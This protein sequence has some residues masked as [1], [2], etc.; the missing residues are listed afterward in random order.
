MLQVKKYSD[1]LRNSPDYYVKWSHPSPLSNQLLAT[2]F[3][4]ICVCRFQV[5]YWIMSFLTSLLPESMLS[6][7]TESVHSTIAVSNLPGP[8][9]ITYISGYRI[10]NMTFWLPHRGSTGIGISILSY[11]YKLQLG[12][13]ADRAVISNQHDAQRILD[14]AVDEIRHMAYKKYNLK[15]NSVAF[16][17]QPTTKNALFCVQN[18]PFWFHRANY[19]T[20]RVSSC[21][22]IY[23]WI[24]WK[25]KRLYQR[26]RTILLA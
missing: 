16:W 20:P 17:N 1:L 10:S 24:V 25:K 6:S 3:N 15:R 26:K 19:I 11:G 12:L 8:Q 18:F 7:L 14:N 4:G 9:T 5:N 13:I 23:T 21:S 2:V 22:N